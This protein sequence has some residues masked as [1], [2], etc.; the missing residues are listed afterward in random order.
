M[1]LSIKQDR[2][3]FIKKSSKFIDSSNISTPWEYDGDKIV[4]KVSLPAAKMEDVKIDINDK[5]LTITR[6]LNITDGGTISRQISY[7]T[8][9]LPD[10]VK[11]SNFKSTS[12]EDGVLTVA[13]TRDA[14]AAANTSSGSVDIIPI[15]AAAD[16]VVKA[17]KGKT[18]AAFSF[19]ASTSNPN[20]SGAL[21]TVSDM[22][23]S[24]GCKIS[25]LNTEKNGSISVNVQLPDGGAPEIVESDQHQ[26]IRNYEWVIE[27]RKIICFLNA[28]MFIEFP[29]GDNKVMVVRVVDLPAGI[30]QNDVAI[31]VENRYLVMVLNTMLED[32]GKIEK[33]AELP[34]GV[35]GSE[36]EILMEDQTLIVTVALEKAEPAEKPKSMIS[37]IKG[38]LAKAW[39]ACLVVGAKTAYDEIT[40]GNA[41]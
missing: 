12:I 19:Q 6:E 30:D 15:D 4:C 17:M 7:R 21:K 29:G 34:D 41:N 31:A 33:R 23:E 28:K 9:D 37:K 13:F 1:S 11:R 26:P 10:G 24:S 35:T 20:R 22:P 2:Y 3:A 39:P 36:I 32:Y 5:K 18:T 27:N 38:A 8:F 25:S 14:A 40:G 16:E